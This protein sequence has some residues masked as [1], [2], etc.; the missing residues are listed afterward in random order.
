MKYFLLFLTLLLLAPGCRKEEAQYAINCDFRPALFAVKKRVLVVT[1]AAGEVLG[2]FDIPEIETASLSKQFSVK[3]ENP[4]EQYDLHLVYAGIANGNIN[5]VSIFS[6]FDVPNGALVSF[7]N[8]YLPEYYSFTMRFPIVRIHDI[9]SYDTLALAGIYDYYKTVHVPAE[10]RLDCS[11]VFAINQN[12][13]LRL[14]ANN[15]PQFRY[16][17]VPDTLVS[18]TMS[19]SWQDFKPEANLKQFELPD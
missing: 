12:L 13:L 14:R 2:T 19:V 18:D 9:W 10:N 17:F 3:I 6:H 15:E 16:C 5:Y 4:P 1:T 8:N 7:F 11:L